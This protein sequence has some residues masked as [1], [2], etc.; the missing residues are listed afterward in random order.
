[1]AL[2]SP[3]STKVFIAY[4]G[5]VIMTRLSL[6][7]RL[8]DDFTQQK[9]T[10]GIDVNLKED[11]SLS[12]TRN[13]SGYYCFSDLAAGGYTVVVSS[14]CY[15]Q[16][17][18][19]IDVPVLDANEPDGVSKQPVVEIT[20]EPLP[21][22]GFPEYATL[23]RGIVRHDVEPVV[24]AAVEGLYASDSQQ[25]TNRVTTYYNGEFVL[26]VRPV[27]VGNDGK[28]A[29][30]TLRISK[31]GDQKEV[32]VAAFKEGTTANVEIIEFG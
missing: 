10:G 11:K 23:I 14:D 22:Y 16:A 18:V 30:I 12:P 1:M 32:A 7:V 24:N 21:S 15:T 9:I 4:R 2:K 17:P 31:D 19:T 27:R 28:I 5:D 26:F 20:L 6:A 8:I 25:A 3:Y 13:P 29:A